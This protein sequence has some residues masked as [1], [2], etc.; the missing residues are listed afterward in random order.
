M[1]SIRKLYSI[2]NLPPTAT[3]IELRDVSISVERWEADDSLFIWC[4]RRTLTWYKKACAMPF[5]FMHDMF[6]VGNAVSSG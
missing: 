2:L 6:L 3:Q 5:V 1:D 4:S